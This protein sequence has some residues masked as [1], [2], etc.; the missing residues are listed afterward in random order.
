VSAPPFDPDAHPD[1]LNLGCGFDHR[2]GYLNVDF[3][4]FHEPDLVAD[5]TNLDMLPDGRYVEIVAQD[6][7][8][9]LPR[10]ETQAV[11]GEW[12]RLLADGGSL[13]LRV[14]SVVDLV[15][16]L[17]APEYQAPEHQERL[18]QCLF[19][20]QAYTG[21]VHLTTFTRP[22]LSHYFEQEG[23][24]PA[25]WELFDGWLFDIEVRKV[26]A[27]RFRERF[28][29]FVD[30]LAVEDLDAFLDASYARILGRAPDPGGRHYYGQQLRQGTLTRRGLIQVLGE[31]DEAASGS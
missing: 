4:V 10:T 9:H 24:A 1:R 23:F 29:P 27:S 21:D 13:Q 22:L 28:A 26:G 20:T 2:A 31:S 8:E 19:G 6:V 11:L 3:Q 15:A 7:L 25:R 18:I 17:Q 5:V 16:L 12:N 30:L 14:P